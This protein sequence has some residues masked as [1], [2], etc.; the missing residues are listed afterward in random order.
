M[1]TVRRAKTALKPYKNAA[2]AWLWPASA[3]AKANANALAAKTKANANAL[4]AK[5]KA[6]ANANSLKLA[7]GQRLA[8][9]KRHPF[10]T[11][12]IGAGTNGIV[13]KLANGDLLK[14]VNGNAAR[15][16]RALS[17]LTAA[18]SQ[19]TPLVHFMNY[20]MNVP[21]TN[22]KILFP[23]AQ[24]TPRGHR[25]MVSIYVMT[26]V[27]TKT[28]WNYVRGA[29]P[30]LTNINKAE[31]RAE[32]SKM[33]KFMH[34]HGISHGDLHPGNILVELGANGR[35]KKLWIIDFGRTINIPPG[36][37][38]AQVYSGLRPNKRYQNSNLFNNTRKPSILLYNTNAGGARQNMNLL[39]EIY[40]A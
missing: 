28:L 8:R 26:R 20:I 36:K 1:N 24:N 40:G 6:K 15:E 9:S 35:M 17:K 30:P 34:S 7:T 16:V 32:I 25:S 29:W 10:P 21:N 31:I 11:E 4:A 18:G 12:I 22:R 23:R 33:V 27:G 39:R 14:M 5:A 19:F 3:K 2:S 37:T 13:F 38:E